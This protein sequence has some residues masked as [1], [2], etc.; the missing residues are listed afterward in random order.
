MN[1]PATLSADGRTYASTVHLELFD[2]PDQH[3]PGG[4][5][6]TGAAT[7]IES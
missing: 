1:P 5:D 3:V 7:R 4:G 6:G 2:R